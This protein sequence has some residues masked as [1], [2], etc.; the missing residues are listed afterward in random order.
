LGDQA[1]RDEQQH[2]KRSIQKIFS[3]EGPR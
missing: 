2:R 1:R 3:H